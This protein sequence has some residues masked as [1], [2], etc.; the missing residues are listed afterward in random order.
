MFPF[1]AMYRILLLCITLQECWSDHGGTPEKQKIVS[2]NA[3]ISEL[4]AQIRSS[5][6]Q[7]PVSVFHK[8]VLYLSSTNH[9]CAQNP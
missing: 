3:K 8:A 4:Y 5:F 6:I 7:N 1:S 9:R 2:K